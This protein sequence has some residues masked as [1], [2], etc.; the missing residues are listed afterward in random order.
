MQC[1]PVLV[2]VDVYQEWCSVYL[3]LYWWM[4]TR[5]GAVCT[6]TCSGGCVPGVMQCVPL[7][8]VVDVYQEWCGPCKAMT[9]S[10]RRVK[11]ELGDELLHFAVVSHPPLPA[12][13]HFSPEAKRRTRPPY[14]Q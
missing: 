9:S 5:S 10:F 3:Y 11:N 13:G 14:W 6:C 8:V 7:L 12:E 4:C 1:V 2:V